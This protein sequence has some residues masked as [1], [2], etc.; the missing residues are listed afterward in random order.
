MHTHSILSIGKNCVSFSSLLAVN[1]WKIE[2]EYSLEK[3]SSASTVVYCS[4]L[5]L[6]VTVV[7]YLY[8]GV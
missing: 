2:I 8:P 4:P 1:L 5:L 3:L 7:C 6:L